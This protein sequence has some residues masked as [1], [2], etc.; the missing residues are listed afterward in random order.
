MIE[1]RA[2]TRVSKEI[3]LAAEILLQIKFS[4]ASI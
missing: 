1:T 3:K 2:K 4:K